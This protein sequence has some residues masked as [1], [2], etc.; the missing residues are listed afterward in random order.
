MENPWNIR[1][2]YELQYFN[3]PSCAFRDPSKQELVNHAYEFHPEAVIFLSCIKDYSLFDV[4]CPWNNVFTK[5]KT[6]TSILDDEIPNREPFINDPLNIESEKHVNEDIETFDI[7]EEYLSEL[8]N[9]LISNETNHPNKISTKKCIKVNEVSIRISRIDLN[10]CHKCD[11]YFCNKDAL[12]QHICRKS[13]MCKSKKKKHS[14]VQKVHKIQNKKCNQCEKSYKN[15]YN[16]QRHIKHTH[17]GLKYKCELCQKMFSEPANLKRHIMCVH[18]K[19][20]PYQCSVCNKAFGQKGDME[21]H[22][23]TV[24]GNLKPHACSFCSLSFYIKKYLKKHMKKVHK[25]L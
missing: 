5:I 2:I 24:H 8:K 15:R 20:K 23:D 4:V 19:Q 17:E 7:T 11:K 12:K 21:I 18:D 9:E 6:E 1:S 10:N 25:D 3:C 13:F 16:L 14:T 22:T